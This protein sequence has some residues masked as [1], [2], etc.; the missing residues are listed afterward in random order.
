MNGLRFVDS[1]TGGEPTRVILDAPDEL[2]AIPV[3]ERFAA[4]S[5]ALHPLARSV[6]GEPRTSEATVGAFLLPAEDPA[7]RASVQFVNDV[8][9]LR[10]CVHGM[11][12]VAATL[13]HRGELAD[14]PH[15]FET[16]AGLVTV[17]AEDD[18]TIAVENVASRLVADRVP[19]VTSGGP[20]R[21]TIAWGG[22]WFLILDPS[23][24]AIRP[25][26]RGELEHLCREVRVALD[27]AGIAGPAGETI[28]HVALF[29][30]PEARAG[31]DIPIARNF[32]L[33]PGGAFD[34]SP[35]GT[36]TSAWLAAR[37]STGHLAAGELRSVESIIGSRFTGSV[38]RGEGDTW[39]P[40][41]RGHAS[42]V[43]EGT[44]VVEDDDP[45]RAGTPRT[46]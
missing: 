44:L 38:R 13:R 25:E 22:N 17:T 20:L 2:R 21:G 28:D 14:G 37:A 27:E 40:T 34:R 7:H 29:E 6:I 4:L 10:M 46:S 30:R 45:Y 41:V 43:A 31:S 9:A 26:R 35:C 33:C 32:V 23:P 3:A 12:G 36:G 19:L 11:I 1:H 5:N 16:A 15:V 42:I 24:L 18:G 8:G 39:I